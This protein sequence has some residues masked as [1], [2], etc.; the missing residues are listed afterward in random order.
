MAQKLL[1]QLNLIDWCDQQVK[2]GNTLTI[3]W[4]GGG[5]SG[6]GWFELNDERMTDDKENEYTT[7]LTDLMY[8]QLDYGSWAGEFN[9]S[10]KA[11]YDPEQKAFI[12]I[13]YYS[14]DSTVYY[15]CDVKIRIPKSLWFDRIE[16]QIQ[17]EKADVDT[18]FYVRNGFLTSA[19]NEFIKQFN[20]DFHEQVWT[21]IEGFMND[22]EQNKYCSMSEDY[23]LNRSEFHEDG[24]YLVYQIESLGIGTEISKK[25]NIYLKLENITVNNEN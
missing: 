20:L 25:K 6:W 7:K 19:H 1:M 9:A 18:I 17:Y 11:V 3:G 8:D 22:Q 10:G 12:G 14:E 21:V 24:D 2:A 5:D 15:D 23:D 13:D 16:I 4:E